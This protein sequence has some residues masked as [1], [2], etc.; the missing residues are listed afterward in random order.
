[1]VDGAYPDLNRAMQ[2]DLSSSLDMGSNFS[3]YSL[4]KMALCQSNPVDFMRRY[5]KIF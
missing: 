2:Y 4:P 1:M 3:K 5:H